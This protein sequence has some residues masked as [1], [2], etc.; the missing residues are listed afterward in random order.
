MQVNGFI[1]LRNVYA[2]ML[3]LMKKKIEILRLFMDKSCID[4]YNSMIKKLTINS[5][6][7]IWKQKFCESFANR[8]W[9]PVT[10]AL[11]YKYKDGS[12]LDYAIRKEKLLLDMRSIDTATLVDIIA[13]GL[14]EYILNRINRE[15]LTQNLPSAIKWPFLK[16]RYKFLYTPFLYNLV[17]YWLFLKYT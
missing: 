6:W 15:S 5:E 13:A 17:T 8:G 4:W 9:S 1:L 11:S 2:L 16:F 3:L 10:Y 12:L 7:S 14:P